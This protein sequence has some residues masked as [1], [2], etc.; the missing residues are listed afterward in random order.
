VEGVE[1]GAEPATEPPTGQEAPV[2]V[3]GTEPPTTS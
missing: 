3:A 2:V 1:P